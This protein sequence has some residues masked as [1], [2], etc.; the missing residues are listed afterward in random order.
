MGYKEGTVEHKLLEDK[1]GF[2]YWTL[3]GEI[4]YA[5]MTC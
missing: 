4:I 1:A 5:Y 2:A 3:L